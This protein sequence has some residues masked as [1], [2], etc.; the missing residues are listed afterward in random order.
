M[1]IAIVHILTGNVLRKLLVTL[2]EKLS[3][4]P[5]RDGITSIDSP[6]IFF[7]AET[8]WLF[9]NSRVIDIEIEGNNWG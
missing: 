2:D 6:K 8:D 1:Q 7:A 4:S 9:S 3:D 5:P